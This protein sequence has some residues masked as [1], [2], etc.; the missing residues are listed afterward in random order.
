M[1]KSIS[2]WIKNN[3]HSGIKIKLEF[4]PSNMNGPACMRITMFF[5]K[6]PIHFENSPRDSDYAEISNTS[7]INYID[8]SEEKI[9][10]TL[11]SMYERGSKQWKSINDAFGY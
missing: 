10:K 5:D 8:L 7:Y 3:A 4:I 11:N 1:E 6:S 2:D 9:V